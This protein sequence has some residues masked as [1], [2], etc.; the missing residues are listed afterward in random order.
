MWRKSKE[1]HIILYTKAIT[2]LLNYFKRTAYIWSFH[3]SPYC[4]ASYKRAADFFSLHFKFPWAL[5][6]CWFPQVTTLK[7]WRNIQGAVRTEGCLTVL[8]GR[9]RFCSSLTSPWS[10]KILKRAR[11]SWQESEEK[12]IELNLLTDNCNDDVMLERFSSV[13]LQIAFFTSFPL[14]ITAEVCKSR[15]LPHVAPLSSPQ[16][17]Y[18]ALNKL[19]NSKQV[20]TSNIHSRYRGKLWVLS[21]PDALIFEA[22][23][24]LKQSLPVPALAI[25]WKHSRRRSRIYSSIQPFP[26]Q[27]STIHSS[28]TSW[29]QTHSSTWSAF[30]VYRDVPAEGRSTHNMQGCKHPRQDLF[31]CQG[32][33]VRG[34]ACEDRPDVCQPHSSL[35]WAMYSPTRHRDAPEGQDGLTLDLPALWEINERKSVYNLIKN[36][37]KTVLFCRDTRWDAM[38]IIQNHFLQLRLFF[39]VGLIWST[40]TPKSQAVA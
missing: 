25:L 29:M 31:V 8:N 23:A 24:S 17:G 2:L 18:A 38:I 7:S 4:T 22:R 40:T 15:I 39:Q 6:A 20:V 19:K 5:T 32:G 34:W 36:V 11:P 26:A 1:P 9:I 30:F 14:V 28:D 21:A 35:Q 37:K 13:A 33:D 16:M 12:V 3:P 27:P 10:T